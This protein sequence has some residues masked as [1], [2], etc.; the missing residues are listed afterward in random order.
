M[1]TFWSITIS[2]IIS[3]LALIAAVWAAWAATTSNKHAKTSLDEAR[4]Q[5]QENMREQLRAINVS[6]FDFRM[7][8]LTNLECD[9][10]ELI[11][12]NMTRERLLFDDTIGDSMVAYVTAKREGKRCEALKKEYLSLV[13]SLRTDDTYEEATD[14]LRQIDDYIC[15]EEEDPLYEQIRD[16]LRTHAYT[17]KW[18][19][20]ANPLEAETVNYVDAEAAASSFFSEAERL[21]KS[22][23]ESTKKYI[24]TSIH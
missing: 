23:I 2:D 8:V 17:G 16:S 6:L 19:N 11:E 12:R 1:C 24:E 3:I 13:R 9:D 4:A 15:M 7:E 5:S 18:M 10:Y 14:L 22:L 21:R 20:G